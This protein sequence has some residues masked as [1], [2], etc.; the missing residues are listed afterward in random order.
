M[1]RAGGQLRFKSVVWRIRKG[2]A[3]PK[4]TNHEYAVINWFLAREFRFAEVKTRLDRAEA[5]LTQY[6]T[7]LAED[8]VS[9]LPD[10]TTEH[11]LYVH[12]PESVDM[13]SANAFAAH[14]VLAIEKLT[15]GIAPPSSET[16]GPWMASHGID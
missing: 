14:N 7:L 10:N 9:Q 12:L 15:N 13:H 8:D 4:L 3:N 2:D 1:K 16:L 11:D 5:L 6:G